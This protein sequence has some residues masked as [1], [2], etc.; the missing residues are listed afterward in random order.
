MSY[1]VDGAFIVFVLCLTIYVI[2]GLWGMNGTEKRRK[3]VFDAQSIC[4]LVMLGCTAI[5]LAGLVW[6][7]FT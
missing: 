3:Q 6:R 1:V 5:I 7:I 2:A 4:F